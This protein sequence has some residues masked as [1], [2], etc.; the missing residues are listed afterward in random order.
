MLEKSSAWTESVAGTTAVDMAN[1]DA[2]DGRTQGRGLPRPPTAPSAQQSEPLGRALVLV[3]DGAEGLPDAQPALLEQALGVGRRI[4]WRK[5]LCLGS[6]SSVIVGTT[7]SLPA[8]SKT[9]ISDTPVSAA[10]GARKP[11]PAPARGGGWS[12]ADD[13]RLMVFLC[14]RASYLPAGSGA[15]PSTERVG[16]T[17]VRWV[18]STEGSGWKTCR[19]PTPTAWSLHAMPTS[20]TRPSLTV[21]QASR[22]IHSDLGNR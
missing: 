18:G 15:Q 14:V 7:D 1:L 6:A 3:V 4:C 11:S 20:P 9:E 8:P 2:R 21:S 5:R 17:W 10:E 22:R 12:V 16:P 13:V 19:R